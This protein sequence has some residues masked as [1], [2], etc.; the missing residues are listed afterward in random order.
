MSWGFS[1]WGVANLR[2]TCTLVYEVEH[3]DDLNEIAD[4]IDLG[5]AVYVELPDD[6]GLRRR[7]I[8]FLSGLIYGL[9]GSI[10]RDGPASYLI[11]PPE[12]PWFEDFFVDDV[13][14]DVVDVLEWAAVAV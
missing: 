4:C 2:G 9:E 6:T 12:R 13:Q 3:I 11:T 8:D 5:C 14:V 7:T 10:R 1:L